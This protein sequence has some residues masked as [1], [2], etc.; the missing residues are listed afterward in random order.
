MCGNGGRC[1]LAFA[2]RHGVFQNNTVFEAIDGLHEGIL[3]K[4]GTISLRMQDV[5]SVIQVDETTY[6]TDTGSPHYVRFCENMPSNVVKE[7]ADIRYSEPY[8]QQGININFVREDGTS[9][10]VATYERGVEN[11]TL[12]CGTGVTA[13]AISLGVRTGKSGRYT[14]KITTKGGELEVSYHMEPDG[15]FTDIWLTGPAEHVF[16]GEYFI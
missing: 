12:S 2:A 11:E 3:L 4:N 16:S 8:R 9:L 6:T 10:F 5:A 14:Q 7:G 15:N 13:A 1:I